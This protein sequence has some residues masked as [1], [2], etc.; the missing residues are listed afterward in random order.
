MGELDA[1]VCDVDASPDGVAAGVE[2]LM[3]AQ[4]ARGDAV[5]PVKLLL[6]A[7]C[8][9]VAAGLAGATG[10]AVGRAATRPPASAAFGK[11][12]AVV[13]RVQAVA[14]VDADA[15]ATCLHDASLMGALARRRR[16]R[17]R[18]GG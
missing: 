15:L 18:R 16:P 17:P 3:W 1:A 5:R 4:V 12:M 13:A 14:A 10:A 6:G 9:D 11:A 8:D 7:G 2:A